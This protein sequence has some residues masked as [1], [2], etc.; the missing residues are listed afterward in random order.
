MSTAAT[1]ADPDMNR[2]VWSLGMGFSPPSLLAGT[3]ASASTR[4]R[5]GRSRPAR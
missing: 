3:P 2:V 5:S 4:C 1:I